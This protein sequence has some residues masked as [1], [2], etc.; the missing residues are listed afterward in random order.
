MS[1]VIT[2]TSNTVLAAIFIYGMIFD[3]LVLGLNAYK[4]IGA[5]LVQR[6]FGGSQIGILLFK[7]GLIYFIIA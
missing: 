3:G 6:K 7:D 4:L 1:C 5:G 2:K